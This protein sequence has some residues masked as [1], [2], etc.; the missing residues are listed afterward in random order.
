ME[1]QRC[2]QWSGNCAFFV[3]VDNVFF[4]IKTVQ[5]SSFFCFANSQLCTHPLNFSSRLH[6]LSVRSPYALHTFESYLQAPQ[7]VEIITILKGLGMCLSV[8][9]PNRDIDYLFNSL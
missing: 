7:I 6:T 1:A 8:L 3:K 5:V 4:I 2:V 9:H